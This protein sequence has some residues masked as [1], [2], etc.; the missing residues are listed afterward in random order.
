MAR[1][2]GN[3]ERIMR[4]RARAV[5]RVI[6]PAGS[7]RDFARVALIRV[8]S[9]I[10]G[11]QGEHLVEIVPLPAVTPLPGTPAWLTGITQV[12]GELMSVVDLARLFDLGG[13]EPA[14]Y[15]AVIGGERGPVGIQVDE[16]LG[17]QAVARDELAAHIQDLGGGDLPVI[18]VT[19]E[20]VR[21]LDT[22]RLLED[23]RLIVD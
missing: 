5:A 15:L 3:S 9:E 23:D 13:G 11:V 14:V 10:I 20:L 22:G 17:F 1:P 2:D 18:G 16:L 8:G 6:E 21:L 7:D 19:R 12:R 4:A